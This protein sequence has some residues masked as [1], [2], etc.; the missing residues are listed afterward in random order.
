MIPVRTHIDIE[1]KYID[2]LKNLQNKMFDCIDHAHY[3]YVSIIKSQNGLTN[4]KHKSLFSVAYYYQNF[5]GSDLITNIEKYEE[6]FNIEF[7][8]NQG[9]NTAFNDAISGF[10]RTLEIEHPNL[11]FKSMKTDSKTTIN[12]ELISNA[13][14]TGKN[15]I[16]YKDNERYQKYIVKNVE[17]RLHFSPYKERGNY[18]IT[19]GMGKIGMLIAAYILKTYHANVIL[20]GRKPLND[21]YQKDI[22]RLESL[23]GEVTYFQVDLLNPSDIRGFREQIINE[24]KNINGIIW[25]AGILM[26]S[27]IMNKSI[28]QIEAVLKPKID[29]VILFDKVMHDLKLDFWILFSSISHLGNLGQADYA[30]ANSFLNSFSRYRS[31]MVNKNERFGKT[32]S[33]N[34]PLW[35]QGGMHLTKQS[36]LKQ[37]EKGVVPLPEIKGMQAIE[38]SLIGDY[39]TEIV[40][41]GNEKKIE[42]FIRT[43]NL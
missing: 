8:P 38:L 5:F 14:S 30:V 34:W 26:D 37:K 23:G 10:M 9:L 16:E 11:I 13:F 21:D 12:W 7:F 32:V 3:P 31:N 33:I 35:E 25:C 2:Y 40:L 27:L 42:N 1:G 19:G 29:A 20:I 24:Y 22:N 18:I 6:D 15:D 28:L 41:Y 4:Q 36:I 39:D 43:L 17:K